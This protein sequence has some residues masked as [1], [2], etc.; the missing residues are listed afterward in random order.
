MF[1][2]IKDRSQVVLPYEAILPYRNTSL[3]LDCP[4][5]FSLHYMQGDAMGMTQKRSWYLKKGIFYC[6]RSGLFL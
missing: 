1:F 2:G 5:L 6:D 3:L 4:Q